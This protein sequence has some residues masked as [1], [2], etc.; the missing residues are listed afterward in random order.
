MLERKTVHDEGTSQVMCQVD[1]DVMLSVCVC[2]SLLLL[3]QMMD[4]ADKKNLWLL[5]KMYY[6]CL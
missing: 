3:V 2:V 4:T 6:T 5:L 1:S